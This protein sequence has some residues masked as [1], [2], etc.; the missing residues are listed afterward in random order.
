[1]RLVARVRSNVRVQ[2][3]AHNTLRKEHT[4]HTQALH[5]PGLR[6]SFCAVL[7]HVGPLARM[8]PNVN[9]EVTA[10]T[11]GQTR[12]THTGSTHTSNTENASCSA[13]TGGSWVKRAPARAQPGRY[14]IGHHR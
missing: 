8:N 10:H 14:N 1:M 12:D 7:A 5:L 11:V 6:K 3:A 9:R 4:A 2:I 13:R